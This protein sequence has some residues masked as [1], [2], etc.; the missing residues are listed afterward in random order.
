MT[1]YVRDTVLSVAE[2]CRYAIEGMAK[3]K[4]LRGWCARASAEIHRQ[5]KRKGISSEIH[6]W[7]HHEC[8]DSHVFIVVEDHV[9]CATATQFS[10]FR[11][12]PVLFL[13]Q[14]EAEGYPYFQSTKVF[15]SAEDLIEDQRRCGWPSAQVALSKPIIR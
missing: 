15:N 5:L 11:N 7:N 2:E 9:V 1:P 13:H 14:R 4:Y 10:E 12:T 3:N 6:M 8:G